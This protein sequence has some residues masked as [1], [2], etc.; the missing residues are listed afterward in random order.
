VLLTD[1][2]DFA[3]MNAEYARWF[4]SD[5]P[6]CYAAELGAEIPGLFVSIRMTASLA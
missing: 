3:G 5:S 2:G 6:A 1:R 4:P